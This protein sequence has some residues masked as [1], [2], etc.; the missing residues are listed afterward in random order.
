M[1]SCSCAVDAKK[2]ARPRHS[3]LHLLKRGAGCLEGS[4][5]MPRELDLPGESLLG[6]SRR[7]G[8]GHRRGLGLSQGRSSLGQLGSEAGYAASSLCR[9]ALCIQERGSE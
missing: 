8:Q 3:Y 7:E 2:G 6:R 5:S 1:G 4:L 9:L